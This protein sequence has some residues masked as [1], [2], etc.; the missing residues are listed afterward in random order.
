MQKHLNRIPI[1]FEMIDEVKFIQI[2]NRRFIKNHY[3]QEIYRF[4]APLT[5]YFMDSI[6]L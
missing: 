4:I 1:G 5:F 6:Y 2:E 3:A